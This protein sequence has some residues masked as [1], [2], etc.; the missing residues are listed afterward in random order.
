MR[1]RILGLVFIL[2]AALLGGCGNTTSVPAAGATD[3][4][5]EEGALP[6][7]SRL[8]MGILRLEGTANAVT[9][10]QARALLPLWQALQSGALQNDTETAAVLKRIQGALSAEQLAAIAAMQLTA[11]R[12][13]AGGEAQGMGPG[14]GGAPGDMSE[15]EF[16]AMRATAEAGGGMP[17]GGGAFGAPGDM[18][19]QDRAAMR[20]TAEAGGMAPGGGQDPAGDGGG[21]GATM[22]AQVIELLTARAA[23]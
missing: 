8:A 22:A 13:G 14:Q 20:A 18:S 17:G 3:S 16:A 9:P 15:E 4:A 21:R 10:E 2:L 23:E 6:D 11:P 19:E 5:A 1:V 7:S 12:A